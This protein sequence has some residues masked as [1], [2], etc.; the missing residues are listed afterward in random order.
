MRDRRDDVDANNGRFR[1]AAGE[2]DGQRT[3][4]A[5]EVEDGAL[6]RLL[7]DGE[8]LVEIIGVLVG[9]PTEDGALFE[10]ATVME[11]PFEAEALCHMSVA[12]VRRE[13]GRD[14]GDDRGLPAA[15]DAGE[16]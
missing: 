8:C 16:R 3:A 9:R 7:F 14:P 2:L 10:A 15:A 13:D 12:L 11:L 4:A 6:Q 1:V 5:A